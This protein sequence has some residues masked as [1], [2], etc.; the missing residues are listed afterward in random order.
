MPYTKREV[1]LLSIGYFTVINIDKSSGIAEI[2]SNNTGHV[3]MINKYNDYIRIFHKHHHSLPYHDHSI[4]GSVMD[5]ILD[6]ICH[7]EFQINIR[8]KRKTYRK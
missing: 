2:K 5:G 7:D 1:N 4:S 3:W 8:N 6:I